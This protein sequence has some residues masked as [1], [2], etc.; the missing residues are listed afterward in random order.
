MYKASNNTQI[1]FDD[2][3]QPMSMH[4][5]PKNRW[6]RLAKIIPW[7]KYESRYADLFK[8]TTGNVAKPFQMA[9]GSL[10]IQKKLGFSDRELVEQITENPYLQYFIGFP[11]YQETAPFDPSALVSFRK[12]IN[13]D[14]A[15]FL[16]D[17]ILT[18]FSYLSCGRC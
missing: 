10:I 2:F 13:L 9:L 15:V 12:R 18:D 4:L 6:V 11:K 3:E 17:S 16:N 5:N 7:S 14:M 8:S 1:S